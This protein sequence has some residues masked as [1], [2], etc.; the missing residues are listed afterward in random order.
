M[1]VLELGE[2]LLELV[3]LEVHPDTATKQITKTNKPIWNI[4]TLSPSLIFPYWYVI[5]MV[6]MSLIFYLILMM[7]SI[8]MNLMGELKLPENR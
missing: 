3:L 7:L 4:F 1:D 6:V 2:L 5:F 8:K